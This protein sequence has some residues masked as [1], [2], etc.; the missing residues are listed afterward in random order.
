MVSPGCDADALPAT[1]IRVGRHSGSQVTRSVRLSA[2]ASDWKQ[3]EDG[4]SVRHSECIN[5]GGQGSRLISTAW[6][7][8]KIAPECWAPSSQDLNQASL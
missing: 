7:V 2:R 3:P 4:C 6:V 8:K 5:Q 1:N